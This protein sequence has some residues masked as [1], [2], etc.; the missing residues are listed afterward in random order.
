MPVYINRDIVKDFVFRALAEDVG[1]GDHSSLA[2]ISPT[3][4]QAFHVIV[5]EKGILAGVDLVTLIL[6]DYPSIVVEVL[7][8]DAKPVVAGDRALQLYGRTLDILRLERLL[9]N[10]LQRM[11]GIA[12]Y[13]ASLVDKIQGTSAKLLDTRK[14]SPT[15]RCFEKWAV[16]L[17]GGFNHRF[18]LYD[19]IML[20]DNHIDACGSLTKA[21]LA[22]Y[23]YLKNK[24]LNLKIEVETRTLEEVQEALK[25]GLVD[26]IMFDNMTLTD[27]KKAVEIV[28]NQCETEAS[29]GITDLTIRSIAKTGVNFIS[30]G[31]LTHSVKNLD[32]SLKV[33]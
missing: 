22:A 3:Q 30:V 24:K 29:G 26:R 9:L 33:G 31:A 28:G 27:L 7:I 15:L 1:T 16:K 12:S 11:S 10:C 6:K 17:G 25:T 19:M 13:T 18:G 2:C 20:K 5:K 32:M 21:V 23:N 4:K 8:A 14:T